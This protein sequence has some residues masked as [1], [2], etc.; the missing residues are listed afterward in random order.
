MD[1]KNW[2][3]RLKCLFCGDKK[4]IFS[5]LWRTSLDIWSLIFDLYF[6]SVIVSLAG[7]VAGF[8]MDIGSSGSSVVLVLALPLHRSAMHSISQEGRPFFPSPRLHVKIMPEHQVRKNNYC[9]LLFIVSNSG[10][11]F[12]C[13]GRR[14]TCPHLCLR[15]SFWPGQHFCQQFVSMPSY[16][17]TLCQETCNRTPKSMDS[18]ST[19][20][21]ATF[22]QC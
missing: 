10:I 2:T 17:K 14:E 4:R 21:H 20:S 7:S 11:L 18:S 19:N 6:T 13:F 5:Y 3:S 12:Y 15:F 8:C 16:C 9:S 1:I 22:I